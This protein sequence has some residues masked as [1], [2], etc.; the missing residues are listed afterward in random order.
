MQSIKGNKPSKKSAFV[1]GYFPINECKKYQG[2]G[3]IIYRSS[4]ERKFCIYCERNPEITWWSSESLRIKYFSVLDNSYH[5]YFPDFL[6]RLKNGNTIIVEIKPKAQLQKP[7]KPKKITKKSTESFKWAY[8]T[9][10]INM[11]KKQAAEEYAKANGWEYMIVTED[12]F[13]SKSINEIRN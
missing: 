2:S 10:L 4:W 11:C 6:I 3:P 1:Q 5:N 12:F 13:K 9:W 8:Q 7:E